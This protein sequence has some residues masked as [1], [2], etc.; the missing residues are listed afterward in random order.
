MASGGDAPLAAGPMEAAT[1][2]VAGAG[3]APGVGVAAVWPAAPAE[4]V[5]LGAAATFT[6]A[7]SLRLLQ[8]AQTR[9]RAQRRGRRRRR[10]RRRGGHR[11]GT[12]RSGRRRGGDTGRARGRGTRAGGRVSTGG[13]RGRQTLGRCD[14]RDRHFAVHVERPAH[15]LFQ[16]GALLT[17]RLKV[18]L[19]R[20]GHGAPLHLDGAIDADDDEL[21]RLLASFVLLGGPRRRGR[22]GEWRGG[23]GR[24]G[25]D[26]RGLHAPRGLLGL[27]GAVRRRRQRK[28]QDDDDDDRQPR[29][30]A[31]RR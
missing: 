15:E 9:N 2:P 27:L 8:G 12:R 24:G 29:F 5:A 14:H 31:S 19:P 20:H 23:M 16:T 6:F 13:R 21:A 4:G 17:G 26:R 1:G 7:W 28:R 22:S 3:A 25:G 11:R 18:D 10:A 30:Q